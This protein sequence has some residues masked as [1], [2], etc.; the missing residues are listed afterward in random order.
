MDINRWITAFVSPYTIMKKYKGKTSWDQA[1]VRVLWAG[2]LAGLILGFFKMLV[3]TNIISLAFSIAQ[4]FTGIIMMPISLVIIWLLMAL[5]LYLSAKL[6]GSKA[7]FTDHAT[8]L[9]WYIAPLAVIESILVWIP[10]IGG[11]LGLLIFLWSLYPLT[12]ILQATHKLSVGGA[13]ITWLVWIILEL[14]V[15]A[16]IGTTVVTLGS[17]GMLGLLN[18][19][20]IGKINLAALVSSL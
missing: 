3:S 10:L 14:I 9:T 17:I 18:Q 15:I 13:V 5:W 1:L 2:A 4:W 19:Y 8:D 6:M 20:V 12:A 11:W 16:L 7:S